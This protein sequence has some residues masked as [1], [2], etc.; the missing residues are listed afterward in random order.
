[1]GLGQRGLGQGSSNLSLWFVIPWAQAE[2]P[3]AGAEWKGVLLAG[4]W[5]G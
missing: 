5:A 2:R 1:M 3:L 4:S